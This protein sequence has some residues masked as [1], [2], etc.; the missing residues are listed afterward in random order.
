VEQMAGDAADPDFAL[1]AAS[2]AGV[3]YQVLNPPYHRWPEEF[4][5]LQRGVMSAARA[6]GARFVS[7]ENLYMY[8]DTGGHALD[9]STPMKPHTRK[10]TVRLE[11]AEELAE[12][13]DKGDL[14]LATA[15]ASSYFGPRATWQSPLGERVIGR[16]LDGKSAQVIGDPETK[17]SYTYLK[18]LSRVLA[19]LGTDGRAVGE[20]WHVPNAPARTTTEIIGMIGDELGQK[21]KVSPAPELVLWIMGLFNPTVRELNE[22]LYEFKNDFVTDGEKFTEAFGMQATPLDQAVAETVEWWR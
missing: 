18:D 20:V 12:L 9:E 13:S 6:A 1:D 17:H 4:P 10:G 7:F 2:G 8:G 21:I 16:A 3:V 15:R 22:M 5:P 14:E 11:M 19:T